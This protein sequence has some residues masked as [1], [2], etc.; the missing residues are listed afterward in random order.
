MNNTK[1][2]VFNYLTGDFDDQV[3]GK[4]QAGDLIKVQA[5][6]MIPADLICLVSSD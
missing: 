5:E 1:C 2:K 6:E 4:V 3:W